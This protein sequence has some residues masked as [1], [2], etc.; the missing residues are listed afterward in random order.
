M[1][2]KLDDLYTNTFLVFANEIK[3][4]CAKTLD[5]LGKCKQGEAQEELGL[6]RDCHRRT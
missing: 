1:I 4:G 5:V 2:L 6:V 3:T